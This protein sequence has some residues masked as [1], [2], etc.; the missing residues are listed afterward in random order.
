MD[1]GN[2]NRFSDLSITCGSTFMVQL[3]N[4]LARMFQTSLQLSFPVVFFGSAVAGEG[5]AKISSFLAFCAVQPSYNVNDT[6]VIVGNDIDLTL[7][8]LAAT[9]YFNVSVLSPS[10]LQVIDVGSVVARWVEPGGGFLPSVDH[11]ASARMDMVF[12][13][14]LNGGDHFAGVGDAAADLWKRYRLVR[15]SDPD[16]SLMRSTRMLDLEFLGKVLQVGSYNGRAEPAPGRSLLR[17][18]L[19]AFHTTVTGVCP[20]YTFVASDIAPSLS[21]VKAAVL[22]ELQGHPSLRVSLGLSRPLSPLATFVALMPTL[23]H[24][25]PG[26]RDVLR[27]DD[28]LCSKLLYSNEPTVVAEAALRA[29]DLARAS[30]SR[31]EGLLCDLAVPVQVNVVQKPKPLSRYEVHRRAS[32]G[33]SKHESLRFSACPIDL[34]VSFDYFAHLDRKVVFSNAFPRRKTSRD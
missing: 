19:W 33:T 11:I 23:E 26:V 20:D 32:H 9:Q 5:E 30:L 31:V 8:A 10:S 15:A 12:L 18:A 14:L 28:K 2:A 24:Q 13:F 21:N 7:T 27:K 16:R 22:L 4:C 34:P 29:V 17:A 1:V 6:V 25:P 3:E